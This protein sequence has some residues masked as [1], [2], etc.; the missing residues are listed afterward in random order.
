MT[1]L[2]DWLIQQFPS[3]KLALKHADPRTKDWFLLW[4]DPVPAI[5]LALIYLAIVILGPR[6][7]RNREAFHIPSWI[8]FSYNMALVVLSIYM[9]EEVSWKSMRF[10]FCIYLFDILDCCWSLS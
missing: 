1:W 10:I 3:Y 6:Y 4:T 8:L 7:M 2:N 5:T 9:V